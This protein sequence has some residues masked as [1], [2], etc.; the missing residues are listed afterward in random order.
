MVGKGAAWEAP[1][2]GGERAW[3]GSLR[4]VRWR[5]AIVGRLRGGRR[6]RAGAGLG[7]RLGGGGSSAP[8]G[9]EPLGGTAGAWDAAGWVGSPASSSRKG[10]FHG[11][12]LGPVCFP[13]KGERAHSSR[14]RT[15]KNWE[16]GHL[17]GRERGPA[18][19]PREGRWHAGKPQVG[20]RAQQTFTE[21]LRCRS[22]FAEDGIN[23][24]ESQST[25]EKGFKKCSTSQ[26]CNSR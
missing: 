12:S 17:Q 8:V 15:P 26:G 2:G 25:R 16:P 10:T 11:L 18:K 13:L 22:Q 14:M 19:L 9:T 7:P 3:P 4:A 20:S 21:G 1:S 24:T 23:K 5:P 6:T